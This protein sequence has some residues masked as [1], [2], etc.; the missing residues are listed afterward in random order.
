VSK[1]TEYGTSKEEKPIH[2][3]AERNTQKQHYELINVLVFFKDIP[4]NYI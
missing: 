3:H 2:G 4:L 1:Y